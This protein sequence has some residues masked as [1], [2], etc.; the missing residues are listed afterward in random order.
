MQE[1]HNNSMKDLIFNRQRSAIEEKKQEED[2]V[3]WNPNLPVKSNPPA[4]VYRPFGNRVRQ[5]QQSGDRFRRFIQERDQ[6]QQ[7]QAVQIL[8]PIR[9]A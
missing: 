5:N 8:S 6:L 7:S 2:P 4:I 3:E 9:G 1:L